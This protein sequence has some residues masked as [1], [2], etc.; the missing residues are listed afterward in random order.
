MSSSPPPDQHDFDEEDTGPQHLPEQANWTSRFDAPLTIS[1]RPARTSHNRIVVLSAVAAVAAV[2]AV[3]AV[4]GLVFWLMQR[5]SSDSPSPPEAE[6]TISA[7]P[8]SPSTGNEYEANLLKLLPA[9]YQPDSCQPTAA[10]KDALAQMNCSR[11]D[12]PGGPISATYTLARDKAALDTVFNAG[13]RSANRVNCPGNIQSPVLCPTGVSKTFREV[14][15][16]G[17]GQWS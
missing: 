10:P 4:G 6:P 2:V 5:Q 9:G 8:P 15:R 17:W 1:P 7:S 11:N 14:R 13:I 16:R 12:D 3:A